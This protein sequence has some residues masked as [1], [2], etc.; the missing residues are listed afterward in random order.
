MA[1]GTEELLR[2]FREAFRKDPTAAYREWFRLQEELRER[3]EAG[4]S[5]SLADDLWTLLGE[6]TFPSAEERARLFH[7]V[8]VFFGTDGPAADL[9]RARDGFA[10]A[11]EH[12]QHHEESGWHARALHNFATSLSNLARTARDLD[13][14]IALFERA[15]K[16]RTAE[17]EIAR[18]VTLHNLGIALRRRAL[19]D[20][21]PGPRRESLERSV[22]CLSEASKIR[23]RHGLAEG[24]A[25]TLFHLGLTLEALA[26]TGE[27]RSCFV[28]S[29][30][31]FVRLGKDDSASI[32]R[33][34]AA[35]SEPADGE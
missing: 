24:N 26:R 15:L 8:A 29:A 4:L 17:R 22:A 32:A 12:F 14:S 9:A 31:A 11:L 7:N 6:L 25:L 27:A 2:H 33:Q 1:G 16:W 35:V 21:S 10:V 23:E 13:E 5:R 34:H 18:G 20:S 30:E 19:R 3:G 28:R